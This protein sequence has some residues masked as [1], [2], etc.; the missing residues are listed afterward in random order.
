[1]EFRC[2]LYYR[3]TSVGE[4]PVCLGQPQ[5]FSVQP[6]KK[7]LRLG[8]FCLSPIFG[9]ANK[10]PGHKPS[11]K[12]AQSNFCCW[13]SFGLLP[14]TTDKPSNKCNYHLSSL[15]IIINKRT[16]LVRHPFFTPHESGLLSIIQTF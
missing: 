7:K 14:N 3:I 2:R 5:P 8:Q 11:Q 6:N 15:I 9:C 1:M 12:L 16:G 4:K 10:W 13:P